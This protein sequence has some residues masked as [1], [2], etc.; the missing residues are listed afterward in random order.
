MGSYEQN[1]YAITEEDM[2]IQ[3]LFWTRVKILV[4]KDRI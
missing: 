1:H 4:K 2:F 3:N